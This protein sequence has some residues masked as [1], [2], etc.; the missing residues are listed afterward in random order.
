VVRTIHDPDH[1]ILLLLFTAQIIWA[2]TRFVMSSLILQS[3]S[4]PRVAIAR[5]VA[6]TLRAGCLKTLFLP[7]GAVRER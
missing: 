7:V 2:F 5:I 1:L 4:A 3:I 6:S